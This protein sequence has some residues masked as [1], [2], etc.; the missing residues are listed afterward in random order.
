MTNLPVL[1]EIST[2]GIHNNILK[3]KHEPLKSSIKFINSDIKNAF[4]DYERNFKKNSL[5]LLHTNLVFKH[6]EEALKKLYKYSNKYLTDYR[7]QVMFKNDIE[8]SECPLCQ[9]D[10][11]N[12]F[13]HYL[14]QSVFPQFSDNVHNLI[15][16]CSI[17]NSKKGDVFLRNNLRYI[18]NLYTDIIPA[19]VQYLA[20][21]TNLNEKGLP[22]ITFEISQNAPIN[23]AV[24]QRLKNTYTCLD[25]I[26]RYNKKV[27]SKIAILKTELSGEDVKIAK[28]ILIKKACGFETLYG[29]NYWEA[30]FYRECSN[31]LLLLSYLIK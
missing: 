17:C 8:L 9:I 16:C 3:R 24:F 6:N 26:S 12:T 29:I 14:P 13:D 11:V 4:D 31:N 2:F 1:Q 20:A 19:D 30:V 15:P 22:V 10:S 25:L 23:A 21:K 18:I 28:K 27:P 7:Q 5:E